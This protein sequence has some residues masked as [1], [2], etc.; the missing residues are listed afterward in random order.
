MGKKWKGM[1]KRERE[2]GS[3]VELEEELRK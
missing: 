3:E 2:R 1:K